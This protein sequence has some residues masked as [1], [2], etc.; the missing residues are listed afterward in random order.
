MISELLFICYVQFLQRF[1]GGMGYLRRSS[2]SLNCFF[3]IDPCAHL[4]NISVASQK[5]YDCSRAR[6][7]LERART[8][9]TATRLEADPFCDVLGVEVATYT[10]VGTS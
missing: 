3:V 5:P 8:K 2:R 10:P 9:L 6:T 1:H 7:Q 4:Y